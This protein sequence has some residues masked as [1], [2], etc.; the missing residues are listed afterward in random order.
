MGL[1][2]PWFQYSF[3]VVLDVLDLIS[4]QI[5]PAKSR[6]MD[7]TW[8]FPGFFQIRAALRSVDS[9]LV[10]KC[11][12]WASDGDPW[13]S[14][15]SK[16][17]FLDDP[18]IAIPKLREVFGVYINQNR[19]SLNLR[20][21]HFQ[22]TTNSQMHPF[23]VPV[24]ACLWTP[25]APAGAIACDSHL[26]LQV[27]QFDLQASRQSWIQVPSPWPLCIALVVDLYCTC[28]GPFI[29]FIRG[30]WIINS[31]GWFDVWRETMETMIILWNL[32][33]PINYHPT[34]LGL[35]LKCRTPIS[36]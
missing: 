27:F 10:E 24:C 13:G 12:P 28:W 9:K 15:C 31:L 7:P 21:Q 32:G 14:P 22:Y 23:S 16:Q 25:A 5:T 1:E 29:L 30:S 4:S 35:C 17:E 36:W 18:G 26:S 2:G 33:H 34:Y 6:N 3:A 19:G 20:V 8:V 11:S